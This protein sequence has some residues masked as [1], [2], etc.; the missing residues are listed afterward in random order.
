MLSI[1]QCRQILERDGAT[2]S[3]DEVKRIRDFLYQLGYLDYE[4]FVEKIRQE[5]GHH[6]HPC[7]NGQ[8]G[9]EGI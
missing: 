4:H 1:K 8:S 3:V 7:L 9:R 6:L 2:Y 5:E